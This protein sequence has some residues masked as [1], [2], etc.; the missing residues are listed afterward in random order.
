MQSTKIAKIY[1][2]KKTPLNNRITPFGAYKKCIDDNR[3]DCCL[4]KSSR[5][6]PAFFALINA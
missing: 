4:N 5:D 1:Y 2:F 6:S 3:T